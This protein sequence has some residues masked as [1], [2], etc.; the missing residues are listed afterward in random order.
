ML[1]VSVSGSHSEKEITNQVR[2]DNV[3]KGIT[4][5]ARNDGDE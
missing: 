1:R 5:Q 3:V 2:N 4:S